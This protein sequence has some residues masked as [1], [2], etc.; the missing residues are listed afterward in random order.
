[1]ATCGAG[2]ELGCAQSY[3]AV[4]ELTATLASRDLAEANLL[5]QDIEGSMRYRDPERLMK[6]LPF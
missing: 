4:D 5:A 2:I 1:L 3:T 6:Y